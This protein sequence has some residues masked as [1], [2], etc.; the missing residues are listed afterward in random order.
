MSD[1]LGYEPYTG[2]GPRAMHTSLHCCQTSFPLPDPEARCCGGWKHYVHGDDARS[3]P[4][5]L[6]TIYRSS[7]ATETGNGSPHKNSARSWFQKRCGCEGALE[8]TRL[9]IVIAFISYTLAV[10]SAL[11]AECCACTIIRQPKIT[12]LTLTKKT[13]QSPAGLSPAHDSLYDVY[14]LKTRVRCVRVLS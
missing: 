12:E 10:G 8:V 14:T 13:T 4:D 9:G 7:T 6:C 2:S 1:N 5:T 11:S 3:W